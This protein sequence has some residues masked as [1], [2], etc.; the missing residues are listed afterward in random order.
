MMVYYLRLG[1]RSL[2]RAPVLTALMVLILAVGIGTSMTSLTLLLALS[3]DPIPQM[4]DKLF[5]PR[6]DGRP[7]ETY[8]AGD[9]ADFQM[10]YTDARNLL[11]DAKGTRQTVLF[12]IAPAVDSGRADLP[13]FFED[14]M[15][16]T[17]DAFAMFDVPFVEGGPWS[18]EDDANAAPV[19]VI[20]QDLAKRLFPN[21]K[22]VG[23]RIRLD[24]RDYTITGVIGVW[25]PV[26]NYVRVYGTSPTGRPNQLWIPFSTAVQFEYSNNGW[27]NCEGTGPAEPGYQGWLDS[28]CTWLQYWVQLDD[29]AQVDAY[30]DYLAAYVAEQKKLGRM[31]RPANIEL[32]TLMEQ[33]EKAGV[34]GNDQRLS[35]WL[36]FGFLGVCLVNLVTLMLAK[37]TARQ[38]DIGVR[39]ALGATRGQI[40]RQYLIEAGVIG[41]VGAVVGAAFAW[42][43][44]HLVSRATASA[45]DFYQMDA[46]LLAATLTLSVLAAL[47]AGL[48]PTWRACNVRPALQLKSQ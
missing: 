22:A 16:A 30:R 1:A 41:A 19:A 32:L 44:V 38:G 45:A 8:T 40:F 27:I 37:F 46:G 48:L 47:L 14:G 43:G 23:Q 15:T 31:P 4:S 42:Y 21:G 11:R 39:R 25:Q 12:G 2:R 9:E 18:A 29:A 17:R 33:L 24:E 20:G 26:P 6:L 13:P 34:V 7:L 35:S 28:E 3:G 36:A 10:T 5:V